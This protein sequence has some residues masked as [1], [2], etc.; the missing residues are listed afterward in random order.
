[1]SESP[2]AA[3]EANWSPPR[4]DLGE[5]AAPRPGSE[6]TATRRANAAPAPARRPAENR[7]ARADVTRR[8]NLATLLSLLFL[9]G[10]AVALI[11]LTAM[12]LPMGLGFVAVVAGLFVFCALHYVL[13]GQWVGRAGGAP[14]ETEDETP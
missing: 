1:M 7:A 12:V 6:G 9:I 14:A 13:W 11:A 10:A 4:F 5:G 2:D 3:R 8:R